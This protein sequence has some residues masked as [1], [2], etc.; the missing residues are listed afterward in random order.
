MKAT[1]DGTIEMQVHDKLGPLARQAV[2]DAVRD[3]NLQ[4][5]IRDYMRTLPNE[6][7]NA[8][9]WIPP[10]LSADPHDSRIAGII[11][12]GCAP[13]IGKP[14]PV[15]RSMNVNRQADTHGGEEDQGSAPLP[16]PQRRFARARGRRTARY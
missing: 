1:R 15:D 6:Y 3:V 8:G 12:S 11:N 9:D 13:Y 16:A 4:G 2:R 7:T 14:I 10:D 5:I